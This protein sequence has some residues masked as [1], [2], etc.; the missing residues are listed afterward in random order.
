M[1]PP[2]P[3]LKQ[4]VLVFHDVLLDMA[5]FDEAHCL[6][7]AMRSPSLCDGAYVGIYLAQA[8]VAA[9]KCGF[10]DVSD[11]IA[12]CMRPSAHRAPTQDGGGVLRLSTSLPPQ[13]YPQ[14]KEHLRVKG[15]SGTP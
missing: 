7:I 6:G 9:R 12:S 8:A 4:Q 10:C 14:R 11:W 3:E 5:L 13:V 2:G 15:S 1:Q